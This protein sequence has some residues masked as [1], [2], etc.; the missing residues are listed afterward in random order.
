MRIRLGRRKPKCIPAV[1]RGWR[2]YVKLLLLGG[3]FAG[4][5]NMAHA[6]LPVPCGGGSCGGQVWVAAGKVQAPVV[7]G[8]TMQITQQSDKAIL[9]W[10]SFNIGQGQEVRF[11]Q[12]SSAAVALNRIH[13]AD[14][15]RINGQLNAN[16]QVYLINQNGI[17]FG[18]GSQVNVNSLVASTLN[19]DDKVFTDIGLARVLQVQ[20][21]AAFTAQGEMGA[22][23]I[24]Q[25]AQLKSADGGRIMIL[26]PLIENAGTIET[27]DGQAI[28]AAAK[29]KV[30]LATSD[31]PNL[32][33]LLVEVDGGGETLNSGSVSAPRG[34]VSLLGF[35][36]N[37]NGIVS[38]TTTVRVNGSIRLMAREADSVIP[39]N[40]GYKIKT[41]SEHDGESSGVIFGAGST[42]EV[43]PELSDSTAAVDDQPQPRSSVEVMAKQIKLQENA[44]IHAPSGKV[45]L[46]ATST[47][48]TP[49]AQGAKRND[50][51]L[52][53]AP[54]AVIDVSG[55][56]STV[57]PME[58]NQVELELRSNE[59]RDSPLQRNGVLQGK[60]VVVDIRKGTPVADISGAVANIKRDIGE[61]SSAGGEVNLASEGD[62]ILRAGSTVDVSG[63]AVRYQDGYINTTKLVSQGKIIDIGDADPNLHYDAV[64][65]QYSR[66]DPKWGI[67]KTWIL[68]GVQSQGVF[69]PGYVEGKDAGAINIKASG[70]RLDGALRGGIQAGPYQ[71]D[72]AHLPGAGTLNINLADLGNAGQDYAAATL[73]LSSGIPL[74]EEEAKQALN[75]SDTVHLSP[76]MLRDSGLAGII[77]K[78]LGLI[79]L[80]AGETLRLPAGGFLKATG[81]EINVAGSVIIPAGTITLNTYA[82]GTDNRPITLAAGARLDA[83]GRWINDNPLL[84]S[85]RPSDPLLIDGGAVT[86]TAGGD[87]FLEAGAL[88][89]A[90]GGAWLDSGG[91]LHGGA[92]GSITLASE[93]KGGSRMQLG[94]ELR[95]YAP[96]QGGVLNIAANS[97]RIQEPGAPPDPQPLPNE[98]VLTPEFFQRGGFR[99]YRLTANL[100]GIT[101]AGGTALLPQVRNVRLDSGYDLKPSDSDISQFSRLVSLPDYQRLPVDL[102]LSLLRDAAE[103]LNTGRFV[104]EAGSLIRT[105]PG[106]T[107]NLLSDAGL[108]ANGI[109]DDPAGNIN[110]SVTTPRSGNE[111][112][113][114]ADQGIWLG[115]QAQLSAES[116]LQLIPNDQ[117]LRRGEL[118]PG[119]DVTLTAARGYIVTAPGSVI[120]VSGGE[121]QLDLQSVPGDQESPTIFSNRKRVI[122]PA[123]SISLLAAEGMLLDGDLRG[124]APAEAMAGAL[125]VE[126]IPNLRQIPDV[127][128]PAPLRDFLNGPRTIELRADG[129]PLIPEGLSQGDLIPDAYNGR[130]LL[131]AQT[132]E[133]GGFDLL[134]LRTGDIFYN[135]KV[136][137]TGE[138]VLADGVDLSLGRSLTLDAPALHGEGT[139]NL[140]APYVTLGNSNFVFQDGADAATG[141]GRL[142][143]EAQQALELVGNLGLRGFGETV[144]T[145]G[146]DL[147][148][149]GVQV[150]GTANELTGALNT[151]G[152]LTL[153]A[154][155]IYP[156]TL[157]HY[158]IE[159]GGVDSR[160]MTLP[161]DGAGSPVLSA[162]GELTLHAVHIEQGGVL[163]APLGT[164]A[165]QA[166]EDLRL[167]QGSLASV[168]AEGQDI[169]F[170]NT[171]FGIDWLYALSNNLN[172]LFDTAADPAQNRTVLPEKQVSLQG[173]AVSLEAGATIDVSGGGDLLAYE[174]I[175]GP[176]GSKDILAPENA[177][178][179]FAIL[180]R[181]NDPLAPYDP[182]ASKGF[183]YLPGASVHLAGGSNL[184]AGEYTILPAR[185]ALLPGAYLVTPVAGTQDILPGI[186]STRADN[187][188]VLAGYYTIAGTAVRSGRW[189]GFVVE[190]GDIVNQRSEYTVSRA[191]DFF[192]T[193]G[194]AGVRLPQDAGRMVVQ[195]ADSLALDGRLRADGSGGGR[196]GALDISAAQISVVKTPDPTDTTSVQISADNLDQLGVESLLLGGRRS[197]DGG[198][199]QVD[200]QQ[201]KVGAGAQLQGP[202]L[203]LAAKQ[204]VTVEGGAEIDAV[205]SVAPAG[206]TLRVSGDGALLR[207]A[208][209]TQ[210]ELLRSSAGAQD[211]VLEIQ[212]GARLASDGSL[213]LESSGDV[214]IN[215]ELAMQ[216]GSL[217]ID[218]SHISLG[219]VPAA[220]TGTVLSQSRLDALG[221]DELLLRSAGA[222]DLYGNVNVSAQRLE[223]DAGGL[224]GRGAGGDALLQADDVVLVNTRDVSAGGGAAGSGG[225]RIAAQNLQLGP[226]DFE[227]RGYDRVAINAAQEARFTGSAQVRADGDV[228]LNAGRISADAGAELNLAAQGKLS[229]GAVAG[230][231]IAAA[232]GLGARLT[233]SGQSVVNEGRIVLPAGEVS[234]DGRDGITLAGGS[235]IDVGGV[236]R[237]YG[238]QQ[239]AAPAGRIGLQSESGDI[240]LD[241]GA[242]LSVAAAA[243]G[244]AGE[245][246]L[247]APAGEV[248]LAG[249]I[250]AQSAA[251]HRGGSVTVNVDQVPDFSALNAAFNQAGFTESRDIRLHQ[252]DVAIAAAD[253]VRTKDLSLSADGGG[254]DVHGAVIG[255]ADKAH[256]ALYARDDVQLEAGAVLR[257]ADGTVELGTTQGRIRLNAGSRIDVAAQDGS[258]AGQVRLRAPRLDSDSDGHDDEVAVDAIQG[259]IAGAAQ[260]SVEAFRGYSGTATIVDTGDW[261][262]DTSQYMSNASAMEARLGAGAVVIPGVELSSNGD[263][264]LLTNWDLASWRY[265]DRAGVLTLRA[266]G[267]LN[268]ASDLSD[269][270]DLG[271]GYNFLTGNTS[272]VLKTGASWSYRLVGGA[273]LNSVDPLATA[274]GNG[275]VIVADGI[276]VRT[277]TGAIDVAA[278]GNFVLADASSTLYTAG[279]TTG[280][281]NF[282]ADY[283]SFLMPGEFPA[284]GGDVS[285]N[286][287]GDVLAAAPA[288]FITDWL[289]RMGTGT[290]TDI[291]ELPTM[292]NID[293]DQ[294]HMGIGALGGGDVNIRA[295]GAVQDLAVMLPTTGQHQGDAYV[296]GG[297]NIRFTDNSVLVLGGGNLSIDAGGDI[298]G[299][300]FYVGRGQGEVR[301]GGSLALDGA[302]KLYPILA[303]ADSGYAVTARRELNL[304]TVVN[305]TL[306]KQGSGQD[307][308]GGILDSNFFSYGADSG[309]TLTALSGDL[310]LRNDTAA[311]SEST[312]TSLAQAQ[313]GGRTWTLT[314]YPGSLRARALQGNIEVNNSFT[315]FPTPQGTLELLAQGDVSGVSD[316]G[317]VAVNL[318][319][320]D[321]ALLPSV[322]RPAASLVDALD[323]LS[324]TGDSA[325]I[326]ATT[327]VHQQDPEPVRIVAADGDIFGEPGR[328]FALYL[329]KPGYISAGRD[330]R[331]ITVDMQNLRAEDVAVVQAGRDIHFNNARNSL[332]N[333]LSNQAHI[334][335]SGPGRV[336]VL[337]GRDIDLGTSDGIYTVG[338]TKNP[339]L[340]QDGAD[341][342]V[343]AGVPADAQYSAF[344][345]RYLYDS[346]DYRELLADYMQTRKADPA[347]DDL[348]AFKSLSVAEQ[349]ALLLE[350][351]FK[352]LQTAGREAA[353]S[354]DNSN[355]QRGFDAAAT[356]FPAGRAKG[357][358]RMYFSRIH[359]IDGGNIYAAVPGGMMNTGLAAT[360]QFNKG[361]D[362]LGIVAQRAGSVDV[363][364]DG[365]MLVN[366]S[367]VFAMDGGDILIWSS[368]GNIDA[369]RGAK[370]ALSAP[371]PVTTYDEQ[372][373]A[374]TEFPPALSGSGIRAA[375]STPGRDP[376]NVDLFAPAGVVNAGDAGIGSEG[377]V[378][379]GAVQVIGADNIDVGGVAVGVPIADTGALAAGLSGLGDAASAVTKGVEDTAKAAGEQQGSTTPIADAALHFLEVEV[380]GFGDEASKQE[381][382]KNQEE[383][384]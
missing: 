311:L 365:D 188:P 153:K 224:Y 31:D 329:S 76:Q 383:N 341:I 125:T 90:D 5:P 326:H 211:G 109:I 121:T 49:A 355:Y 102:S 65:G 91:K 112:G 302:G 13:Q 205:G 283:L 241:S 361:P 98:L 226:G 208:G 27:P 234:I 337:A 39:E 74:T 17:I 255:D 160:L 7:A 246:R 265:G 162:G 47:P 249:T 82:G 216:G 237:S 183:S 37:Q 48:D 130:A 29:N 14:P 161:G 97:L 68:P 239:I 325:K 120:D 202:E 70:L 232:P 261:Q 100:N 382:E 203:L 139:V 223:F 165:L 142:Q 372:G 92:G 377:N 191:G 260:L 332:G 340:P 154:D 360:E 336:D 136:V 58:R 231:E 214:L 51:L 32:R 40:G 366:Q 358:L 222:I 115:P 108:M 19:V 18:A 247:Q 164:I 105:D 228:A 64:A 192:A 77:L 285:L 71:R 173:K 144:L 159:V 264:S 370:S 151:T 276:K 204:Q 168:S 172:L 140:A 62:L 323:R 147:R 272:D 338:N 351:F 134:R 104:L 118:L 310:H 305:P 166:D 25:G 152:T 171:Q 103:G 78:T 95:A 169:L 318:S 138:I 381:E 197:A 347:V 281:G 291:T 268:I 289:H 217:G 129:G 225:L 81:K 243:G 167:L 319:D 335:V 33:G 258:A 128:P 315:L 321:P 155:Q 174:F 67:T 339:V 10:A 61:R 94:A 194:T 301:S 244:D 88:I 176:G 349:R 229:L 24:E 127:P 251:G 219:E 221:V 374:H 16:G 303:L 124:N 201:V 89:D 256:I 135:D 287:G 193:T 60:K 278:G 300:V 145:S 123:G 45:T 170:G 288:Q 41:R 230:G 149:R 79:D 342:V 277:G 236:V 69:E 93:A 270:F 250:D 63:G 181:L 163:K 131:K 195:T 86:L 96:Q 359:T 30:Y 346:Q 185:Y 6:E 334:N 15:S 84:V 55:T 263:L 59:L 196:G 227:I 187:T 292:W 354:G 333:L 320:T 295:A 213:L 254:I 322:A 34:N 113:Y 111:P 114:L 85:D 238:D 11:A 12:P 266:A 126:L 66:T 218:A 378:T 235:F 357:D 150:G 286:V 369:G 297:G 304:E 220:Q 2:A 36:V 110:L 375:V 83:R 54:G 269:G 267:D 132:I 252:G 44:L 298:R 294:Y 345:K 262:T 379:I 158:R 274:D 137:S 248:Q 327:P 353:N 331:D 257:A 72:A 209:G 363:Y 35:A 143:V 350:I 210:T 199:I 75:P 80:P 57:L 275:D 371:P 233:L 156:S 316:L 21:A 182:M 133:Q 50:S 184:P 4:Q 43:L 299:G 290:A 9:N 117:G 240:A 282:P 99:D 87:L 53:L 373:V 22:I 8:N 52:E 384:K 190:A 3:V 380:L 308:Q 312:M 186:A 146:G 28:L 317:N 362:Q 26:A 348:E 179:S 189:Q 200:A 20:G 1:L 273:D 206:D 293:F 313:Q 157:S 344:I 107:V 141:D 207:A 259:D 271:A 73:S 177:G 242:R 307:T 215:G 101:V 116:Q 306:L 343:F 180:P 245:L 314:V 296:D 367:R 279:E 352:E 330:V 106:A 324:A 280:I 253:T 284:H 376:G 328:V 148:L 364:V 122:A 119:G 212:D 46:T 56:T 38:A 175:P 309:V 23:R 42:T 178:D 198:V 368:R 356:L